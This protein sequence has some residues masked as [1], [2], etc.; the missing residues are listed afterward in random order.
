VIDSLQAKAKLR[1]TD[2]LLQLRLKS[3]YTKSSSS[4]LVPGPKDN[5][6]IEK[7]INSPGNEIIDRARIEFY[8]NPIYTHPLFGVL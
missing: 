7:E 3:V 6:G 4:F 5:S 1:L 2:K 8:P